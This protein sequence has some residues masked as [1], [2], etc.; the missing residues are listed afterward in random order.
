MLI[1]DMTRQESMELLARTRVGRLACSREGQPY[2]TPLH[3][4]YDDG[5][6][7]GFSTLGQKIT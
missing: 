4:E 6:L 7:Y 5:H 1:N 3:W 2:I